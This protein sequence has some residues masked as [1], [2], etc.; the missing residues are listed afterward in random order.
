M[1]EFERSLKTHPLLEDL[2]PAYVQLIAACATSVG[3]RACDLLIRE[4]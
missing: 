1:D 4:G 2:E 3:F